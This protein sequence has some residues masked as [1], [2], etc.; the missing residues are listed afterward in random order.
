MLWARDESSDEANH[1]L[2]LGGQRANELRMAVDHALQD[3]L[4]DV[5]AAEVRERAPPTLQ[6]GRM[7]GLQAGAMHGSRHCR[8]VLRPG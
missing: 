5:E 7:H 3:L 2:Q 1:L 8:L 4:G 6:H